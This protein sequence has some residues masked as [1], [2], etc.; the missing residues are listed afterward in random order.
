[1][2]GFGCDE[3]ISIW[4]LGTFIRSW[5]L[6]TGRQVGQ[7]NKVVRNIHHLGNKVVRNIH[8]LGNKVVRNIH[9]PGYKVIRNI[10]HLGNLTSEQPP[11][12]PS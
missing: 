5:V 4:E 7:G 11:I 10:H 1:M 2:L 9:H 6:I 8:H 3:K 12:H